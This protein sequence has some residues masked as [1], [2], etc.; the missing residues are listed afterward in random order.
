[1]IINNILQPFFGCIGIALLKSFAK[2]GGIYNAKFF[3]ELL[4]SRFFSWGIF[5]F[6]IV[7][8]LFFAFFIQLFFPDI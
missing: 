5:Y 2:S 4:L 1:M 3:M 6:F 8:R 7:R